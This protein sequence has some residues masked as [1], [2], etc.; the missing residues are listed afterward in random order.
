[1]S[2]RVKIAMIDTGTIDPNAKGIQFSMFKGRIIESSQIKDDI[3]HGAGIY[4]II[5]KH[6]KNANIFVVKLF[7]KK[8]QKPNIIL[9]LHALEYIYKFVQ[10]HIINISLSISYSDYANYLSELRTICKKLYEKNI[11]IVSAFD[12]FGSISYPA[13]FPEVI[14]VISGEH[15]NKTNELEY[16]QDDN[17]IVNYAGF[18]K[19]QSVLGIDGKYH[20]SQGNSLACAHIS[21]II[22]SKYLFGTKYNT[23]EI[24]RLLDEFVIYKYHYPK[25]LFI[26]KN[27]FINCKKAKIAVLG[28]EIYNMFRFDY[29]LKFKIIGVYDTRYSGMVNKTVMEIPFQNLNS[30]MV[31]QDIVN[32]DLSDCDIVIIGHI[33][34]YE[35][36]KKVLNEIHDFVIKCINS[37][38]RIFSFDDLNLY[39]HDITNE[40]YESPVVDAT[41]K[42]WAPFGK[43]FRISKPVLGI[44]GTS[45]QQ[46]KYTLQLELRKRFLSDGYNVGQVGTEPSSILFGFDYCFHYGHNSNTQITRFDVISLINYRLNNLVQNGSDILMVGGQSSLVPEDY[47]NLQFVTLP[48]IEFFIA[49]N[50]DI[51]IICVNETDD[52]HYVSKTVDLIQSLSQAK[53]IAFVLNPITYKTGLLN[54]REKCLVDEKRKKEVIL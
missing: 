48:Q 41:Q 51:V 42:I 1:M 9:L 18:G 29:M 12:N 53:V 11:I 36:C 27:E 37:K 4:N 31:I 24:T 35:T 7:E 32:A 20:M 46:G 25:N 6:C 50:P 16:I 47:G 26:E 15:C 39:F 45:S 10:C 13:M 28:K 5:K 30:K 40:H 8:N 52:I 22:A 21:G 38:K 19:S 54:Q 2:E 23:T 17:R 33:S 44:Y 3:G 49:T 14:G 34:I 43:L